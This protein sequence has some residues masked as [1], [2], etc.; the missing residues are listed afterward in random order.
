MP[1]P[2]YDDLVSMARDVDTLIAILPGGPATQNLVN[3]DVRE[4]LGPRG[5]FFNMARGSVCDEADLKNALR[6]G[7]ILAAGLDVYVNEPR[8]DPDLMTIPN[9]MLLPHV[10]SASQHTRNRMGQLMVDNLICYANAKPPITP[11]PETP[12]MGWCR[13]GE[14]AGSPGLT[15]DC[16]RCYEFATTGCL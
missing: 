8:I 14:R 15:R 16:P 5:I 1:Y 12:F 4:A 10:G 13:A 6:S 3:A 7:A 11:V 2:F 9:R